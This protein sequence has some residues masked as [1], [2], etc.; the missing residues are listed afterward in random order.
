ME[1]RLRLENFAKSV[2]Q[3]S[4]HLTLHLHQD[5]VDVDVRQ[6][7]QIVSESP[8]KEWIKGRENKKGALRVPLVGYYYIQYSR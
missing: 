3:N 6:N 4:H 2:K 8:K 1:R 7:Y 5:K